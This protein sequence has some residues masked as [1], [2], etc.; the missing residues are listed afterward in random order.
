MLEQEFFFVLMLL[1]KQR[2]LFLLF[3][4]QFD[5]ECSLLPDPFLVLFV[6]DAVGLCAANYKTLLEFLEKAL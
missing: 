3:F 2:L 6:R 1:L 4:S 5:L